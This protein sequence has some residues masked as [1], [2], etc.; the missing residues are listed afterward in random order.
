MKRHTR[1]ANVNDR[2]Q[3]IND[4]E[5]P[6]LSRQYGTI[7]DLWSDPWGSTKFNQWVSFKFDNGLCMAVHPYELRLA[8]KEPM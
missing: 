3:F 2:C 1:K 7:M 6:S 5:Y 8:N 4:S